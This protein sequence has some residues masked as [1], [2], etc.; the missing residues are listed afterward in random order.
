MNIPF[1]FLKDVTNM[2]GDEIREAARSICKA[3]KTSGSKKTMQTTLAPNTA[4][5]VRTGWMR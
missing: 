4:S 3:K 1:L 5:V 2:H